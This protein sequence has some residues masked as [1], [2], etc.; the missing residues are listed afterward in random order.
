MCICE[1]NIFLYQNRH[2]WVDFYIFFIIYLHILY[3]S[4]DILF[5]YEYNFSCC[6]NEMEGKKFII[7]L[8]GSKDKK[9]KKNCVLNKILFFY[10]NLIKNFCWKHLTKQFFVVV[11]QIT[12]K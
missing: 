12:P 2:K 5:T 9:K 1:E 6:C 10:S 8:I 3:P 4:D 11:V 7:K